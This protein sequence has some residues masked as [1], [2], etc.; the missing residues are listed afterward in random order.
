MNKWCSFVAVLS[1]DQEI[2]D[3][4]AFPPNLP[5]ANSTSIIIPWP[6]PLKSPE[7]KSDPTSTVTAAIN[8]IRPNMDRRAMWSRPRG[9]LLPPDPSDPSA[10]PRFQPSRARI[11]RTTAKTTCV[12]SFSKF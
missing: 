11:L 2:L 8:A 3:K 7:T 10:S 12:S 4:K 5:D 6:R 9:V 1:S